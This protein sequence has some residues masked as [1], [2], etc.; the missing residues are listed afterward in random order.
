MCKRVWERRMAEDSAEKGDNV[1][2]LNAKDKRKENYNFLNVFYALGVFTYIISFNPH[3]NPVSQASILI[4]TFPSKE[5]AA[6]KFNI[7]LRVI[8]HVSNGNPVSLPYGRIGTSALS[9][10]DI[11]WGERGKDLFTQHGRVRWVSQSRERVVQKPKPS[12]TRK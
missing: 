11:R 12:A 3:V 2:N 6:Q 1:S 8:H 9:G 10:E 4:L 7:L 5:I